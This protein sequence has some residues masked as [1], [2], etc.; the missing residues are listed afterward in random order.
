MAFFSHFR[1]KRIRMMPTKTRKSLRGT[2]LTSATPSVPTMTASVAA[3]ANVPT[4][5]LRQL[6]VTPTTSTIVKA[7]TNSTAEARKAA[8]AT[9]HCMQYSPV[10]LYG[11]PPGV[12]PL[13]RH[14]L[15]H[16]NVILLG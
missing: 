1:P 11:V 13:H 4:S 6:M 15:Y 2:H 9:A 5:E 14:Q 3:A 12:K 10:L 7:S 16:R 8:I